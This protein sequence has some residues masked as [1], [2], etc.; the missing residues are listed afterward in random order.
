MSRNRNHRSK[1]KAAPVQTTASR[2]NA[3][4]ARLPFSI[5]D[6]V[7]AEIV[8]LGHEGEGVGRADGF[9]LF[10]P[11]ALPGERVRAR[12]KEMKKQFGR[13]DLLELLEASPDRIEPPC[14]LF[15]TCGGCQLQHLS[16]EA[17]LRHKQRL[18]ADALQRI[19]KLPVEVVHTSS[20]ANG[21]NAA[22]GLTSSINC[23]V[24][25]ATVAVGGAHDAVNDETVVVGGAHDGVNDAT[26]AAGGAHDGV[27]DA[28]VAV[29]GANDGVN[30]ATVAV[31][32]AHDGVNDATVAAGGAHDG[33]ND[34]T[35][36]VGGANDGVNDAT[37]AVG[38]ANDGVNDATVAVGGANDAVNDATVAVSGANA[39]AAPVVVLPT[40]GMNEPW[41]YRNK[42]QV[43]IGEEQGGLVGGFYTQ[44]SH[45]IV[46]METCLIQHDDVDASV[47]GVKAIARELGIRPYRQQEHTGELR[48]VIVKTGFATGEQMVVLVTRSAKLEREAELIA[49]IRARLP[50]VVSIC[51]NVQPERTSLVFGRHTRVLWGREVIHDTIGGI[52]FAISAQSFYQVNPAQ[53]EV[54]YSKALEFAGLTGQET[55][56]DAYCG[57]GT[58]SLF[59]AQRAAKVYG[60]EI[61]PEAIED[62]RRNAELNGIRNAEFAVGAAEDVMP[63]W[64]AAGVRPDVIVVDPPRKGCD[65]ALLETLLTMRPERIV[66]V[67]CNPATLARD[68]QV[69]CGGEDAAYRCVTAQPVDMF[70]HTVHVECVVSTYRVDK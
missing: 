21:G 19:G 67:S 34:A 22:A 28:T 43:P 38:G 48:H 14:T 23:D 44:G 20:F 57:I 66:Y 59:L 37:V 65:P 13:A 42:A 17:E 58:I 3:S 15:D 30:D 41:R 70:P 6:S 39:T 62:A 32:G 29:G 36:A 35:V 52:R 68:L 25:N 64:L 24:G 12:V 27:N 50:L 47:A 33:V 46:D 18:V 2:A 4:A 1:S 63:R 7:E 16:Y 9:T 45:K 10:I 54:L 53:T 40:L 55:V 49:A 31:G 56:I 11:G 69:L 26:V 61:V 5:G 60:V 8:G 51:H